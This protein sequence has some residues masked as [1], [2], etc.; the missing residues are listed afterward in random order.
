MAR[1]IHEGCGGEVHALYI[2]VNGTNGRR[3]WVRFGYA[4]VR[5]HD[6]SPRRDESGMAYGLDELK[7]MA[8]ERLDASGRPSRTVTSA[9]EPIGAGAASKDGLG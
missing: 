6:L 5:C 1:T 4:C 3:T 7:E 2:R 8:K 9:P